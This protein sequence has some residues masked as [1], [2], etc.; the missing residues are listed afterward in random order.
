MKIINYVVI[1]MLLAVG[2]FT[3]C[4]EGGMKRTEGLAPNVQQVTAEEVIQ[5]SMYTY[6][7][8]ADG[9]KDYWVAVNK[10]DI[11]LDKTYYWSSGAEM[12]DFTSK[13]LNRTFPSIMFVSDFTDKPITSTTVTAPQGQQMPMGQSTSGTPQVEQQQG[14]SVK[15]AEGG[16]T[17]AELFAR[18]SE[19]NGK[20]I[21]ISGKVVKFS[22]MIMNRN[23]V[24]IQDGT[25]EG[26]NYDLTIT[27][28]DIVNPGDVVTFDGILSLNKD[29][30]AGYF[31]EVIVE[32][33]KRVQGM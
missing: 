13:E 7:R 6:V 22:P 14:I 10:A 5:T 30:G 1:S 2:F 15:K 33:G 29:F 27:T 18:K 17:I 12:R 20:N 16:V 11:E 8:V 28:Q 21:R 3:S 26:D 25:K 9:E 19:L 32:N 24:H 23:W 31:Y 4:G